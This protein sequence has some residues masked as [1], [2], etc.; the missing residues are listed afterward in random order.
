MLMNCTDGGALAV[1]CAGHGL[2]QNGACACDLTWVPPYCIDSWIQ[3]APLRQVQQWFLLCGYWILTVVALWRLMVVGHAKLNLAVAASPGPL[4]QGHKRGV[5]RRSMSFYGAKHRFHRLFDGP[6]VALLCLSCTAT[7]RGVQYVDPWGW[8]DIFSP[9]FILI[10]TSIC[11][12][13]ALLS[14]GLILRIFVSIQ[15]L[16][17]AAMLRRSKV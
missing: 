7:L 6:Y 10:Y 13:P 9:R 8:N 17:F 15:V 14:A 11:F 3:N 5:S 12:L 1:A 16:S 2:C 4:L